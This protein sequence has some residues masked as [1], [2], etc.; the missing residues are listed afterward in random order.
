MAT[1]ELRRQQGDQPRTWFQRWLLLTA[2]VWGIGLGG[3]WNELAIAVYNRMVQWS[4]PWM[5]GTFQVVLLEGNAAAFDAPAGEWSALIQRLVELDA[6]QV[7]LLEPPKRADEA[8]Y[9]QA[10]ALERVILGRGVHVGGEGLDSAYP[11][12]LPA[13]AE[14]LAT[15]IVSPGPAPYGVHRRQF[16]RVAFSEQ[17][18]LPT[19]ET[20]ALLM[21]EPGAS[22][23]QGDF[24]INFM[25]ELERIPR[26]TLE[27][28][29]AGNLV[30]ELVA[31]R[32]ILI[33]PREYR[34]EMGVVTPISR[35]D[36]PMTPGEFHTLAANTLLTHGQVREGGAVLTL[37]VVALASLAALL[38]YHRLPDPWSPWVGLGG[39]ALYLGLGWLLLVTV[40]F[41]LPVVEAVAAH[42]L[43]LTLMLRRR[44]G[45][46]RERIILI[47]RRLSG[48]LQER[49]AT[50]N[51]LESEEHWS[52]IINLVS[53]TLNLERVMFLERVPGDHR[54]KEI[55]S[56]NCS[57]DDIVEMRRDYER[58]PYSTAI[59][60]KA[61]LRLAKPY[62]TP[63]QRGE[64]QYLMPLLFGGEVMGFWAFTLE[65]I[66]PG[67]L[68]AMEKAVS[69]FGSQIPVMLHHRRQWR[70][71]NQQATRGWRAW[72]Q[73]DGGDAALV[74]DIQQSAILLEERLTGMEEV[75]HGQETG[76]ILYNLFGNV[77]H[78]NRRMSELAEMTR[79]SPFNMTAVDFISAITRVEVAEAKEILRCITLEQ[80][81]FLLPVS[82]E[83]REARTLVLQAKPL[84]A[85]NGADDETET[86]GMPFPVKGILIELVD[87]SRIR[88]FQVFKELLVE[89]VFNQ[90]RNDMEAVVLAVDLLTA[91][92]LPPEE[93]EEVRGLLKDK[94]GNTVATLEKAQAKLVGELRAGGEELFP[95][96]PVNAL[97]QAV[98]NLEGE[99]A[100]RR[101]GVELALPHAVSLILASPDRLVEVFEGVL[102]ALMGDAAEQTRVVVRGEEKACRVTLAFSNTGFGM[103]ADRFHAVMTSDAEP[104]SRE[105]AA[106]RLALRHVRSWGGQ[107]EAETAIGEG[108]R[109]TL[110]F[111]VFLC[112]T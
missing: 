72:L 55:K 16:V 77:L 3:A 99:Q 74:I 52:Q 54:L 101:V 85:R 103:P 12:P 46:I 63:S 28:A 43:G 105:F 7:I 33:A 89:S 88:S 95:V 69:Q 60:I 2:L 83:N 70:T 51:F 10:A 57:L 31:G 11:T 87:V 78:V 41:R 35:H 4:A 48:R 79:L 65:E 92:E 1:A 23:S 53:Q 66:D 5:G 75:F 17:E 26:L 44:R 22:L 36:N 21:A 98:R 37:L 27:Q 94:I 107:A 34:A 18:E 109:V 84:M 30:R 56:L 62:L 29:L 14:N 97:I 42:L 111:N 86:P 58:T 96:S 59:E 67:K 80:E 108:I 102:I 15:G 106:L 90:I 32:A 76:I 100:E 112:Q 24:L 110:T 49:Y 39:V 71:R 73:R 64:L 6:R 81:S 13:G 38:S 91:M 20:A 8:W 25:T 68:P 82:G 47:L 45:R 104:A 50:S 19:V 93:R 40:P 61:P 9:R